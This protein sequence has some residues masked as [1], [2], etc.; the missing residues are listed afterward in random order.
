LNLFLDTVL[1]DLEASVTSPS[2]V[3]EKCDVS[4]ISRGQ[5][6]IR[7]VP[8]EMGVHTVSVKHRGIHIPG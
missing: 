1:S 6:T 5:Y 4:E 7:F 2:G 3:T 8:K